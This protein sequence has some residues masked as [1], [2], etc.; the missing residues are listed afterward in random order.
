MAAISALYIFKA[1]ARFMSCSVAHDVSQ[2]FS[3]LGF[4]F[5]SSFFRSAMIACRKE[6]EYFLGLPPAGGRLPPLLFLAREAFSSE[7]EGRAGG[8]A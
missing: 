8:F 5:R 2:V 1:S 6:A 4:F 3:G 7:V